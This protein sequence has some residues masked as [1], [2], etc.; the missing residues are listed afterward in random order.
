MFIFIFCFY[1]YYVRLCIL[2]QSYSLGIQILFAQLGH[3]C[4]YRKAFEYFHIGNEL[5]THNGVVS[6]L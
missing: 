5:Y 2:Q 6:W 1:G 4:S 3:F